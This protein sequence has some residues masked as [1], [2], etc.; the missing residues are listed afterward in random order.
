MLIVSRRKFL[1]KSRRSK[2]VYV[3]AVY[4][5]RE[6]TFLAFCAVI[7]TARECESS[8]KKVWVDGQSILLGNYQLTPVRPETSRIIMAIYSNCWEI[9]VDI[10]TGMNVCGD[11]HELVKRTFNVAYSNAVHSCAIEYEK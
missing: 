4:L 3:F 6:S 7:S 5:V 11:E 10:M 9:V 1:E 2:N 8:R